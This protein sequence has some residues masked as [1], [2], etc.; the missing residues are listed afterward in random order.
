MGLGQLW[1]NML[2]ERELRILSAVDSPKYLQPLADELDYRK[3]TVSKALTGLEKTELIQKERE[4][5]AVVVEP[6]NARCVEVLQSL[7]KSHPHIDFPDLLTQSMINVLFYL[8]NSTPWTATELAEQTGHSRST[9][10]RS[11]RTLT[12]RAMAVKKH[13]QY[14]LT[15]E[16]RDLHEFAYDLL[17]HVHTIQV[18]RNTASGTLVWE[19]HNEYLVR[20]DELV[21]EDGYHRT[22]LDAFEK[23]G[24]EFFTTSEQYYFYSEDRET[25]E[26]EDVVCHLLLI[27]NDSRRRKYALLLLAKADLSREQLESTA[28]CYPVENL[29]LKLHEFLETRGEHP[30]HDTPPW[31]EF[32]TLASEYGVTV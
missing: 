31:E 32:E 18:K 2:K 22:G 14:T 26:A 20:T 16:F 6:S 7:T 13:G 11:L 17:H 10:Y 29:V 5:N 23:Y 30:S 28:R 21:D 19:S 25:L 8:N 4:G 27:G 12:N 9:V 1:D 24:L 15:E 3:D